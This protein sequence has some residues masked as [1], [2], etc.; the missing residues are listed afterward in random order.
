MNPLYGT[1][2]AGVLGCSIVIGGV[3]LRA[4]DLINEATR[5]SN[6]AN[7]HQLATV[8][9]LYELEHGTYPKVSGGEALIEEL[10]SKGYLRSRPLDPDDFSYEI[11]GA[12]NDY[13]LSVTDIKVHGEACPSG[14][15]GELPCSSGDVPEGYFE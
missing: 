15:D 7:I 9:E 12:G 4:D 13:T 2:I 6:Q 1:V 14:A 11:I 3:A 10:V 8:L 5:V